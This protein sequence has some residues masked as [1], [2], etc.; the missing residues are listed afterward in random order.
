MALP[1]DFNARR[2]LEL[3]PDLVAAYGWDEFQAA[4]HYQNYGQAEGRNYAGSLGAPL[5]PPD[6]WTNSGFSSTVVAIAKAQGYWHPDTFR[7]YGA[8]SP[9]WIMYGG[10]I[11]ND[12]GWDAYIRRT[13]V[14][15]QAE[16][17]RQD[18]ASGDDGLGDILAVAAIAA[19]VYFSG[20]LAALG[21]EAVAA[22]AV[23]AAGEGFGTAGALGDAAAWGLSD[24]V[25]VSAVAPNATW[26]TNAAGVDVA[27]GA[28]MTAAENEALVTAFSQDAYAGNLSGWLENYSSVP[29]AD[30]FATTEAV[31]SGW[32]ASGGYAGSTYGAATRPSALDEMLGTVT[33]LATA[34]GTAVSAVRRAMAGGDPVQ[35]RQ[36]AAV[37]QAASTNLALPLLALVGWAVFK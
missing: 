36:A 11:P 30:P 16:A 12:P 18:A 32:T 10:V 14:G 23:V 28:G 29:G 26:I 13:Q 1:A 9:A 2:Y 7:D 17:A 22:E 33:K 3:N 24:S 35:N 5:A 37:R 31:N 21:G 15:G 34:G 6:N 25:V 20:G 19:A 8:G 27:G 4:A